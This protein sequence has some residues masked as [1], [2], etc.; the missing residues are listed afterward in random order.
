MDK[1]FS[2]PASFFEN[3]IHWDKALKP[4]AGKG[5]GSNVGRICISFAHYLRATATIRLNVFNA[6]FP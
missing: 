4:F 6:P 1:G 2:L 3:L 5:L